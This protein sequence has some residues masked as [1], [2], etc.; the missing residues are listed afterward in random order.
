MQTPIL[1]GLVCSCFI[2]SEMNCYIFEVRVLN[3]VT[4]ATVLYSRTDNA[5]DITF[6]QISK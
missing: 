5:V 1:K 6:Y 3:L 4:Y 2:F